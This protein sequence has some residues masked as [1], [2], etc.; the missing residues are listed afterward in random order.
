M[1]VSNEPEPPIVSITNKSI[2]PTIKQLKYQRLSRSNET[3]VLNA[4]TEPSEFEIKFKKFY[5]LL[6]T[7]KVNTN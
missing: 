1:N 3:L 6:N 2:S 5:D 4:N 7:E